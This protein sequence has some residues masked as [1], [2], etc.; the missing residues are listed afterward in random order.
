MKT[1]EIIVRFL[2]PSQEG[3]VLRNKNDITII[4]KKVSLGKNDS[5]ENW[6]EIL[7]EIA[8]KEK[9]EREKEL[10]EEN[11]NDIIEEEE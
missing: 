11:N 3:Y 2:E 8:V 1:T 7:E 6:E 9:E 5:E 10:L 4:S